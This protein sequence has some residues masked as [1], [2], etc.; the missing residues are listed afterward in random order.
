VTVITFCFQFS[1][2]EKLADFGFLLNAADPSKAE[3]QASALQTFWLAGL[4][5]GS[6]NCRFC[7]GTF[8]SF[9]LR[10]DC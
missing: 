9:F 1:V 2:E 6:L 5:C 3:A 8:L 7:P 4:E 10:G